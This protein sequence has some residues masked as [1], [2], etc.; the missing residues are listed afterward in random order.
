VPILDEERIEQTS[1]EVFADQ[2]WSGKRPP[3]KVGT[4]FTL[5]VPYS[6]SQGIFR[7]RPTVDPT[8]RP[9][10]VVTEGEVRIRAE[11]W[12]ISEHASVGPEFA[13]RRAELRRDLDQLRKDFAPHNA[14]LRAYARQLVTTRRDKILADRNT[15][16]T[17]GFPVR[18]RP[19]APRTYAIP[20]ERRSLAI[21]PRG[22]GPFRP[23]PAVDLATYERCIEIM[24]AMAQVVEQSPATYAKLQETDLRNIFLIQLNGQFMGTATGETFRAAGKIDILVRYDNRAVLIAECKFYDGP[25][26]VTDALLQ[27]LSYTTWR[28]TKL[29][30]MMFARQRD[31]TAVL[32]NIGRTISDHSSTIRELPYQGETAF[33]FVLARADDRERE[34]TLTVLVF[35][36]PLD[37]E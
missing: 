5:H 26:S 35:A 20:I 6:G 23:E 8:P 3:P 37:A 34:L 22:S 25:Q 21:A 19:N 7:V 28:D 11:R 17:L 13:R 15:S 27:L 31:F 4:A 33:R 12:H 10:A 14:A 32:R 9:R 18:E 2:Q 16:A 30:L 1:E 36:I 24:Q 29:V